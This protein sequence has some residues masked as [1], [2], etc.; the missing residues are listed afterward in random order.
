MRSLV[1]SVLEVHRGLRAEGPAEPLAV[2]A[3]FD[4]LE[5]AGAGHFPAINPATRA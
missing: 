4:S 2:A 5:D 1:D 3:N